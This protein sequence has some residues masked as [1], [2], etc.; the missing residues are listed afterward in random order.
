M[1]FNVFL[2]KPSVYLG[3]DTDL[4]VKGIRLLQA[5]IDIANIYF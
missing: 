3:R 4:R 2:L 5:M 1:Y